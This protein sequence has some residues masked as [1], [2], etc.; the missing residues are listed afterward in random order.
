M[1]HKCYGKYSV[2]PK[3]GDAILFYNQ[4]PDGTLDHRALHGGCP[5]LQGTKWAAN[6]WVWNECRQS[7]CGK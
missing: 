3:R 1:T 2:Y 6:V 4:L 5:V 7:Q